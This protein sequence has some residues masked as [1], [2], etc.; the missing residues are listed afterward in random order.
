M[1]QRDWCWK[2]IK[3]E[4]Y[5]L[6]LKRFCVTVCCCCFNFNRTK[7]QKTLWETRYPIFSNEFLTQ[8]TR[9]ISYTGIVPLL[10]D[11]IWQRVALRCKSS[12]VPSLQHSENF[13]RVVLSVH[14]IVTELRSRNI[15]VLNEAIFY[16]GRPL[17]ILQLIL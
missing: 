8:K 6:K 9:F 1:L 5:T 4:N 14:T 13:S 7:G 10:Q 16:R 2:E 15:F 3:F 12:E 17:F 11:L